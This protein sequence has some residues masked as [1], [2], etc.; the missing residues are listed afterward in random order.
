MKLIKFI[1][2]MI[3]F[4]FMFEHNIIPYI[5]FGFIKIY[6][7]GLV[8]ALGILFSYFYLRKLSSQKLIKLK[9]KH[10]EDLLVFLVLG[11]V[12]G[13]KLFYYGIYNFDLLISGTLSFFDFWQ[14]GMSFH[15]ALVG[16]IFSLF[17]FAKKY[18]Y[19]FLEI[20]DSLTIPLSV[21]LIFGRIA[22]FVNGELYGRITNVSWGVKFKNVSGYRHPS[23]LYESFKNLLISLSLLYIKKKSSKKG[24]LTF[25]FMIL[26]GVLRFLVE[27]FRQPDMQIGSNG[28]FI[29]GI[30]MGQ[31][32][33]LPLIILGLIGFLYI[34]KPE[35]FNFLNKPMNK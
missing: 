35:L 23:Q 22:N 7:Y 24:V 26:Y 29:F 10:I 12:C 1:N 32:L 34:H 3:L 6:Y 5:N 31:I 28:F 16:A 15:G 13:S 9:K 11:L 19:S 4:G 17:L 21:T 8:Y 2:E 33:S 18:K 20:T 25:S 27:F 14:A 30:T